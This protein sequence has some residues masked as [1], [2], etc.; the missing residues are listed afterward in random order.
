MVNSDERYMK[1]AIELAQLGLGNV[2]PNPMVGCVIVYEDKIIGEGY[3][4]KFG[5]AHAE[6][7]AIESVKN[8]ELL[9]EST[10]YVTLEPCSHYGKTPPCADLLIEKKVKKVFIGCC[11]PF[12]EVDGKGINKLEEAGIRAEMSSLENECRSLNKRFLTY[13]EKKRPFVLLKWAQSQDGFI[14]RKNF[15]SKWI[16]NQYSRQQVHQWRAE[17]DAILVGKNTAIYDNPML[18]VRDAVGDNPTRI[19]IDNNLE[20]S[21]DLNLFDGSVLTYVLNLRKEEESD[22]VHHLKYD[23]TLDGLL[24]KLCDRQIQSVLVEGGAKTSTAFV[25]A[26]LWDEARVFTSNKN[27]ENGIESPNI[28]GRLLLDDEVMGDRIEI[29]KNVH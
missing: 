18:N 27:F 16:S 5:K 24:S 28:G 23:G 3:H 19:V 9:S 26:K 29:Y 10:V 20:L 13:V 22:S 2:S 14:G 6:V 7:N 11:D 21:A 4:E 15:D 1:R 17:E 12:V 25:E 8:Q